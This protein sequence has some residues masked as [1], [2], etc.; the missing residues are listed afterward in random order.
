ML[1]KYQYEMWKHD[2]NNMTPH[3]AVFP[4]FTET[5]FKILKRNIN[6]RFRNSPVTFE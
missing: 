2:K 3:S 6:K 5:T 4:G 1:W